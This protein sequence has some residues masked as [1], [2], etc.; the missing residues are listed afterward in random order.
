V[1]A[2]AEPAAGDHSPAAER[3]RRFLAYVKEHG[4]VM[5]DEYDGISPGFVKPAPVAWFASHQHTPDGGNVAYSYSYLFAYSLA[6]PQGAETLSLPDNGKIRVLAVTVASESP[7]V[8]PAA[9]LGDTLSR[10]GVDMARWSA[11]G[12]PH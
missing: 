6:L 5:R 11:E 12:A 4:P 3:A 8:Q 2:P 7:E 10:A 9:P 1:P